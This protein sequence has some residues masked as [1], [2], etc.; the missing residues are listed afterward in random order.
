MK[1]HKIIIFYVVVFYDI[2]W[3]DAGMCNVAAES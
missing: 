1:K 3:R 2:L